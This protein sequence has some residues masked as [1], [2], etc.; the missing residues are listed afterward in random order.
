MFF[1]SVIKSVRIG[2]LLCAYLKNFTCQDVPK[3][4]INLIIYLKDKSSHIKSILSYIRVTPEE[5]ALKLRE[6]WEKNTK[7]RIA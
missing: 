3:C 5:Y 1:N 7:L 2:L 4:I 6:H